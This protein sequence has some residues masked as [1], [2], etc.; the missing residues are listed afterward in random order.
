MQ[1]SASTQ[2]VESFFR[3][4]KLY[5][6]QQF[7][8]RLPTLHDLVPAIA[9]A[10]DDQF[11]NRQ[12]LVENK[13][14]QYH[15]PDRLMHQALQEASWELNPTGI[16]LFYDQIKMYDKRRKHMEI[17][18]EGRIKETYNSGENTYEVDGKSCTCSTFAQFLYCRHIV[19]Y[20]V[21][22][23]LPV[24]SLESVHP[25]FLKQP[26]GGT[27]HQRT[28]QVED[29]NEDNSPHSPGLAMV[30]EEARNRRKS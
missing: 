21:E 28:N 5:Q 14:M 30:M 4:L 10:I 2:A 19:L 18:D 29:E 20:R 3:V 12:R 13:R 25:S 26:V 1:G 8:K 16:K 17:D 9:K 22:H 6:T 11:G 15:H 7:G 23:S 24:F 27:E